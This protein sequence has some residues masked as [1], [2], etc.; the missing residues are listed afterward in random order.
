[1]ARGHRC[2]DLAAAC[3]MCNP[4]V[5]YLVPYLVPYDENLRGRK[6]SQARGG[7]NPCVPYVP[8]LVQRTRFLWE[9]AHSGATR[10]RCARHMAHMAHLARRVAAAN[11]TAGGPPH[12]P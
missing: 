6:A 1:M 8:Y 12:A 2:A 5:P 4:G 11:R 9:G 7:E 10:P 3:H